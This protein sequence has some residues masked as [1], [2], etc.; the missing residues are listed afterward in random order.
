M[1]VLSRK[2]GEFLVLNDDIFISVF[3][4]GGGGEQV[5]IAIE[6]PETVKI[7]RSE[8]FEDSAEIQQK[9]EK[10]RSKRIGERTK[11]PRK[12]MERLGVPKPEQ[13]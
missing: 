1:L 9:L 10:L 13:Q 8:M 4:V 7:A 3:E 2:L 12:E 11:K 6:A 5:K